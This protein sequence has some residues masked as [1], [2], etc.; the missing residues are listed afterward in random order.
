MSENKEQKTFIVKNKRSSLF[1]DKD[2]N[3]KNAA[4]EGVVITPGSK[5]KLIPDDIDEKKFGH[6]EIAINF[7]E[8][9]ETIQIKNSTGKITTFQNEVLV[10]NS[11]NKDEYLD[12]NGKLKKATTAKF[13]IDLTEESDGK[14]STIT[15]EGTLRP[16]HSVPPQVKTDIESLKSGVE[17]LQSEVNVLKTDSADVSEKVETIET[18]LESKA[19][20]TDLEGL[21]TES[22]VESKEYLTEHQSLEEFYNKTEIDKKLDDLKIST[23]IKIFTV[24]ELK[25]ESSES[26]INVTPIFEYFD[27]LDYPEKFTKDVR[28]YEDE[29]VYYGLKFLT[30]EAEDYIGMCYFNNSDGSVYISPE[31]IYF[32]NSPIVIVGRNGEIKEET[33][34]TILRKQLYFRPDFNIENNVVT[35][36]GSKMGFYGNGSDDDNVIDFINNHN[37]FSFQNVDIYVHEGRSYNTHR[38]VESFKMNNY[39]NITFTY[40]YYYKDIKYYIQTTINLSSKTISHSIVS[41]DINYK[42]ADNSIDGSKLKEK[43]ITDKQLSSEILNGID[44]RIEIGLYCDN[45]ELLKSKNG[46]YFR[47]TVTIDESFKE[48]NKNSLIFYKFR[49]YS[50]LGTFNAIDATLSNSA[51]DPVN[52]TFVIPKYDGSTILNEYVL[53]ISCVNTPSGLFPYIISSPT[54]SKEM[55]R[56]LYNTTIPSIQQEI[57]SINDDITETNNSL[58]ELKDVVDLKADKSET[59]TKTDADDK[60]ETKADHKKDYDT[61]MSRLEDVAQM[62]S[63]YGMAR[64]NGETSAD[65]TIFFGEDANL[66]QIANITHLGYFDKEGKLYKRCANNRTDLAVDGTKL[67]IDGSDGDLL[68]YIDRTIYVNRFTDTVEVNG[69]MKELN[70][71]AIG[72]APFTLYGHNAKEIKPFAIDPHNP[73]YLQLTED[74]NGEGRDKHYVDERKCQHSIYNPNVGSCRYDNSNLQYT[75]APDIFTKSWRTSSKGYPSSY[76]SVVSS[77]WAAQAKNKSQTTNRPYMGMYY[78]FY[79]IWM[80]LMFL[81]LKSVNHTKL[82]LFGCGTSIMDPADTQSEFGD[83][84]AIGNTGWALIDKDNKFVSAKGL[85]V[86]QS[87]NGTSYYGTQTLVGTD[88][89]CFTE[90]LEPQRIL[91]D[92]AAAGL[93]SKIW[94]GKSDGTDVDNKGLIFTH[95]ENGNMIVCDD[96]TSTD[97]GLSTNENIVANQ[98]YYQVRSVPG[99]QTMNDGAMTAVINEFVKME[100]KDKSTLSHIIYKLSYPVYRGM[101]VLNNMRSMMQ[102]CHLRKWYNGD[103]LVSDFIYAENVDD[104]PAYQNNNTGEGYGYS[105]NSSDTELVLEK[106]LNGVGKSMNA[107]GWVTKADYNASLFA[108]T[109]NGGGSRT[110]ECA[111]CWAASTPTQKKYLYA[112]A[113]GESAYY[114]GSASCRNVY[115]HYAVSFTHACWAPRFALPHP[116]L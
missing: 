26:G 48:I 15:E 44:Q 87:V 46:Y 66:K 39:S 45:L 84:N 42:L 104:I 30:D 25:D 50:N 36:N 78:A 63:I 86:Q 29:Y 109:N 32:Y 18:T 59:Y 95:D 83:L 14:V 91:N 2:G 62:Y 55:Q 13:V 54:Q 11:D 76:G 96:I 94:S 114:S 57:D 111:Y 31:S 27:S 97:F 113:V 110:H 35:E 77:V 82:D 7:V 21:A 75:A 23:D 12:E 106:G 85:H 81:E 1:T 116:I 52:V 5:P 37:G 90:C 4:D 9:L 69:T 115:G 102:G 16:I 89:Y 72:L 107:N 79:E 60:F 10:I 41:E 56:V 70:V 19:D 88:Y 47:G 20:K 28:L 33:S 98:R 103:T 68:W 49:L 61:I 6:G 22:W 51:Y 100:L 64:V 17:G 92:I 67:Y 93:V 112:V 8:G 40:T 43:S 99:C 73:C 71:F 108:Y 58:N 101:S 53:A 24:E 34:D 38:P 80:M 74:N 105:T 3:V 65:A